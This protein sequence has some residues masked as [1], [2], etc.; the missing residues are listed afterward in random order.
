MFR[1]CSLS[2]ACYSELN[3][4]I[5]YL[6]ASAKVDGIEL[7]EFVLT[8]AD[9]SDADRVQ[10]IMIRIARAMKRS[11]EIEFYLKSTDISSDTTE[12]SFL[13]NK[14]SDFLNEKKE[15]DSIYFKI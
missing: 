8:T 1:I 2:G 7:I 15:G 13:M 14:Y 6:I 11:G 10:H 12:A 4:E 9:E 5:R 3:T